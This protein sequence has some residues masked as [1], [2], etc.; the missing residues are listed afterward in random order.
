M[1][2]MM[3]YF[4]LA[5]L[6]VGGLVSLFVMF[7]PLA[8]HSAAFP[9][10]MFFA[11]LA[12]CALSITSLIVAD[13]L[14]KPLDIIVILMAPPVGLFGGGAFG[15]RLGRRYRRRRPADDD[16]EWDQKPGL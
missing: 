16:D 14:G 15:Y 12:A 11:G 3:F 13:A 6:V 8:A 10:A 1:L 2:V 7:E 4:Y 5:L 9:F